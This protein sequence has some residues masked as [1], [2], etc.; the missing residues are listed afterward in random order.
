MRGQCGKGVR[1]S[2][3]ESWPKFPLEGQTVP[4]S[5][6]R[7]SAAR[8][9]R[10]A[11]VLWPMLETD[12]K[13]VAQQL[14]AHL[15]A[16][17][18]SSADVA[19]KAGVD[20]KTVDRLRA[21]NAVR[22]Q[23]LAWIEQALKIDLGQ[24]GA[25]PANAPSG[26]GGYQ[27]E[28]VSDYVGEYV[29]HRRSFDNPGRIIASQLSVAWDEEVGALRFHEAQ[30]NRLASGKNYAYRFGG[31]V[32]IPPNLGVVNFVVRSNDGRVRLISTSL[33]R[34]DDGT[35]FLK[36][37]ILTLN[38]IRDIGYYPVTSPIFLARRGGRIT[39]D[40]GIIDP[41]D[42]TH[43]WAESILA[44]IERKFLAV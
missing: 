27:R 35:L 7:G 43:R 5:R 34:D 11:R 32:L 31:D 16:T 23:T 38:E 44:E 24:T 36:G 29:A 30:D 13:H 1:M 25:T 22:P 19:R 20:R 3:P 14:N 28:A 42:Q 6:C 26:F 4:R 41:G 39:L 17:R 37:F 33:P 12:W 10:K 18:L 21:G 15:A 9:K 2:G 8:L 40:T